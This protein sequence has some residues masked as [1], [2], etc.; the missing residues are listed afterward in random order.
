[1]KYRYSKTNGIVLHSVRFGEGHKIIK[2]Y[3]ET[4]GKIDASAFGVRK[5]KSRFGSRLEQFTIGTFLLYKKNEESLYAIRDVDVHSQSWPVR[6]NLNKFLIAN[7]L[8]E[9]IIRY[10]EIAHCDRELYELIRTALL[11]LDSIDS[12]KSLYLL[13]M[14]DVKFLSIM[15]YRPDM[16][17]CARCGLK[18]SEG[19]VYADPTY[20]VPLC[21]HCKFP[22]SVQ[23]TSGGV[24][25][26]EWSLGHS[27]HDSLKVTMKKETLKNI[28]SVLE[29][30]YMNIFQKHLESWNQLRILYNQP[31]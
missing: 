9:T 27:L 19:D 21:A 12:K 26:V 30:I 25:F 17:V 11:V 13:S 1:M 23:V 8:V 24:H 28:R 15:G 4:L 29:L 5:T 10:V 22:N 2:L 20:G 6:E 18:L 7:A 31:L 14:Y 3:T 16:R